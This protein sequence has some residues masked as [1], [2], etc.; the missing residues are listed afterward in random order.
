MSAQTIC[1]S[2]NGQQKVFSVTDR[3]AVSAT[4]TI[5]C[6][7]QFVSVTESIVRHRQS[8]PVTESIVC[9]RQP[10]SVREGF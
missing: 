2:H 1:V 6:L 5:I 4:N 10:L 7:R 3:K 8:V 9:H